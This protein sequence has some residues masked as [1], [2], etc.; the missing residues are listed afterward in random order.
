MTDE[1]EPNDHFVYNWV[2]LNNDTIHF[3]LEAVK[4][5]ESLLQEDIAAIKGDKDLALLL[6]DRDTDNLEIFGELNRVL[7]VREWIEK[8]IEERGEQSYDYDFS[9][10]HGMA[11]FLKSVGI[12]Y[13][14]HLKDRRNILASKSRISTHA[15]KAVD[16]KISYFDEK[17]RIGIFKSTTP[18]PLLIN[19]LEHVETDGTREAPPS[20][21]VRRP[22]P[23]L[24]DSIE[25]LD[26]ELR[27]R[28]LDLF[29]AFKT[30]GQHKRLD[31][32]VA[33]ATRILENRLRS[34]SDAPADS[35][36]LELA[37]FALGGKSPKLIISK[38][39]G[40]Q[41]SVHLLFR[42]VF[43][44]IRNPVHHHLVENLSPERVLQTVG[45]IDYLIFVV[46]N[47]TKESPGK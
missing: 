35:V 42:G 28:C 3:Y 12:L 33:E 2:S 19:E 20:A 38:I 4:Y 25:I 14:Q 34:I 16:Q 46:E 45:M 10:S 37:T 32:V 40:E 44:F 1:L 24:I 30:D 47:G 22:R 17:T 41:E 6:N 29:Q 18:L 43:G 5:Y 26:P 7:R 39:A 31:T 13:L 9:M 21:E 23:I 36:G 11:R 27:A 15:L 8:K